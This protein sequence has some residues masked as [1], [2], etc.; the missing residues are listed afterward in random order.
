MA[1]LAQLGHRHH[2]PIV[3][4]PVVDHRRLVT[5]FVVASIAG[6]RPSEK[7]VSA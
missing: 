2:D 3:L 1:P 6:V 7:D 4:P 5:T